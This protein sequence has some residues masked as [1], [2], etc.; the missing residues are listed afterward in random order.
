[1]MLFCHR[2]RGLNIDNNRKLTVETVLT[3]CIYFNRNTK[4]S[5]STVWNKC[6][7]RDQQVFCDQKTISEIRMLKNTII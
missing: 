5:A 1:M 2:I 3:F 6:F 7:V 4:H